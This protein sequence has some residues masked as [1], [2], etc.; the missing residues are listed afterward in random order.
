MAE[1]VFSEQM[2][3]LAEH[4]QVCSLDDLLRGSGSGRVTIAVTFD[5]GYESVLRTAAPIMTRCGF[6]GTVFVNTA[7]I[8]E[9][10]RMTSDP[11]AG[12]YPGETFLLW[13][14]V[15]RLR[16]LGW[17][18][19]SH[20]THHPDLTRESP[21]GLRRQLAESKAEIQQQLNADCR[22]FAYPFGYHSRIVR[23]AARDCGYEWA[24][25]AVHGPVPRDPDRYAVPR[26]DVRRDLSIDDFAA[27]VRGD[28]DYLGY[29]QSARHVLHARLGRR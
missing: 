24:L 25:A 28:W 9:A 13:D 3:W 17:V 2:A 26:I 18:I 19:G 8:A 4:A 5:D 1:Q 6:A 27:V 21:A 10:D 20:G 22:Y 29:V 16:A 15:A 11:A 23:G 7:S 14:E 12:Y